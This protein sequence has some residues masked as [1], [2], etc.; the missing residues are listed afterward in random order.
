MYVIVLYIDHFM[1]FL[2]QSL[3]SKILLLVNEC[4]VSEEIISLRILFFLCKFCVLK[5]S[6][7]SQLFVDRMGQ[8]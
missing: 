1:T 5:F 6:C 7:L 3:F 2:I 8:I 4:K